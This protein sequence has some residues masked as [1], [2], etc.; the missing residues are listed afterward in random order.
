MLNCM[1]ACLIIYCWWVGK[2]QSIFCIYV[3]CSSCNAAAGGFRRPRDLIRIIYTAARDPYASR[4]TL[5]FCI[6]CTQ[7]R[8]SIRD[9]GFTRIVCYSEFLDRFWR[10]LAIRLY[11]R[12]LGGAYMDARGAYRMTAMII[13]Y[14]NNY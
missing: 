1:H 8:I 7:H 10:W 5:I 3:H 4:I 11:A 14:I 13:A 6:F 12:A 2:S 9:E